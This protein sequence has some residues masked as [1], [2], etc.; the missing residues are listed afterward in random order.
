MRLW[1]TPRNFSRSI[2]SFAPAQFRQA[3][4]SRAEVEPEPITGL[5][6]FER[7]IGVD[8]ASIRELL[9]P[10]CGLK[11]RLSRNCRQ[12]ILHNLGQW[13]GVCKGKD[14]FI[15]GLG[16]FNVIEVY[17]ATLRQR[18]PAHSMALKAQALD[19]YKAT[20]LKRVANEHRAQRNK[21]TAIRCL[22]EN[23]EFDILQFVESQPGSSLLASAQTPGNAAPTRTELANLIACPP[24]LVLTP[25]ELRAHAYFPAVVSSKE[26]EQ[27]CPTLL[28]PLFCVPLRDGRL[29]R[30][31]KI[32]RL[33]SLLADLTSE[34]CQ[35]LIRF[36][37]WWN[38]EDNSNAL[39]E[40]LQ[41]N[42]FLRLSS[43]LPH[44]WPDG[45]VG[46]S[47]PQLLN[48]LREAQRLRVHG[49]NQRYSSVL[50]RG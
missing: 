36:A 10:N 6:N 35:H 40:I 42:S 25:T 14:L 31:P 48:K 29:R 30:P 7:V 41:D 16:S 19:G 46:M 13:E 17:E 8:Q 50:P 27:L 38:N 21:A 23:P 32:W 47:P 34:P 11:S 45:A 9:S 33:E 3:I 12:A 39:D 28:L 44:G 2:S 18:L 5:A 37:Q 1:L 20:A 4:A 24:S 15:K 49:P 43:P 26:W 22:L